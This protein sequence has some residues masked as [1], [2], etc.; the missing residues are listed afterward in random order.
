VEHRIL[1]APLRLFAKVR[2]RVSECS[3][4]PALALLVKFCQFA[5][6]LRALNH[7]APSPSDRMQLI[8]MPGGKNVQPINRQC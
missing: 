4:F 8:S 7:A 6:L 5:L 1:L 3:G 2:A